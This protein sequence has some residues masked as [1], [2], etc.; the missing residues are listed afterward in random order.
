M[1]KYTYEILEVDQQV[2][3]VRSDGAS[4]PQDPANNDYAEYLAQLENEQ[5]E[6]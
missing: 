1:M 4:I 3:I 2:I 6:S 5:Q